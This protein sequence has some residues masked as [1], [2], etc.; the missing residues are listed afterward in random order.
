MKYLQKKFSCPASWH[1]SQM[2]WDIAFLSDRELKKKYN[3]TAEALVA[4]LETHKIVTT[5]GISMWEPR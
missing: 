1:T 3:G 5:N 2:T 4:H